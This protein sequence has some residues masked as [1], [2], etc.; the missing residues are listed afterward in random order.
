MKLSKTSCF[1]L[2]V[3]CL[4]ICQGCHKNELLNERP[5]PKLFVPATLDDVQSLLDNNVIINEAPAFSDM[6]A[7]DYYLTDQ[8]WLGFIPVEQNVYVWE[9]DI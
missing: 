7:G 9:K 4:I 5:V 6:S 3:S 1:I 8:S 2:F